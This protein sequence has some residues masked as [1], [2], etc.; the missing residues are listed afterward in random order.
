MTNLAEEIAKASETEIE[1]LLE[2]VRTR[3]NELFPD[4]EIIMISIEKTAD[5]NEQLDGMIAILQNMKT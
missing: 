4:W 1:K 5:R 2:A 3:Y